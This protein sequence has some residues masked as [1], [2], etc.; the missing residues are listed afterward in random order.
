MNALK[1]GEEDTLDGEGGAPISGAQG[2]PECPLAPPPREPT[3]I[4]MLRG[5]FIIMPVS[6]VVKYCRRHSACR[7]AAR[8][9]P[10][11]DDQSMI[12][13]PASSSSVAA[14]AY[15]PHGRS[16]GYKDEAGRYAAAILVVVRCSR[17]VCSIYV[18]RC[19]LVEQKGKI[20]HGR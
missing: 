11:R 1:D 18:D 2:P 16:T 10:Y 5:N 3:D 15:T 9:R 14:V 4:C 7:L 12:D 6:L 20:S 8:R 13:A 17:S 19:R